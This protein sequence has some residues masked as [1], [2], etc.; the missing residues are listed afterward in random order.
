MHSG[1][2]LEHDWVLLEYFITESLPCIVAGKKGGVV[3]NC[4]GKDEAT[5][6]SAY[7]TQRR[8][9]CAQAMP[10]ANH[11]LQIV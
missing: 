7:R 1:S 5:E 2:H 3:A 11:I 9:I 4:R 8:R 10:N 6:Q